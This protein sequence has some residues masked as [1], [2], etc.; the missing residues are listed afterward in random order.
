MH[1]DAA[2]E[3]HYEVSADF[4]RLVLGPRLKYSSCFWPK[5]DTTFEEAEVAML[6]IYCERAQLEDGMKVRENDHAANSIVTYHGLLSSC[7]TVDF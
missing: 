7:G 2:N 5:T 1:T 4:Y 3:Q 6:E